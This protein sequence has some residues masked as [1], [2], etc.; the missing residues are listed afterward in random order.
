EVGFSTKWLAQMLVWLDPNDKPLFRTVTKEVGR[1]LKTRS[2]QEQDEFHAAWLSSLE[3][4]NP[5]L[6]KRPAEAIPAEFK[7]P[8]SAILRELT[9]DD[10][11]ETDDDEPAP[12][13]KL[14][15]ARL[16]RRKDWKD[17]DLWKA[18]RVSQSAN[19]LPLFEAFP[20]VFERMPHEQRY[21]I[22]STQRV[23]F[24]KLKQWAAEKR[25]GLTPEHLHQLFI[26]RAV[27]AEEILTRDDIDVLEEMAQKKQFTHA[28]AKKILMAQIDDPVSFIDSAPVLT[29]ML[30][31]E[32]LIDCLDRIDHPNLYL[33][34]LSPLVQI[35]ER[36]GV[37]ESEILHRY[38]RLF[39][40]RY[41]YRKDPHGFFNQL[42]W[43]EG[44]YPYTHAAGYYPIE[45]MQGS[46]LRPPPK[47]MP[48]NQALKAFLKRFED[49]PEE[50][51]P[52][53]APGTADLVFDRTNNAHLA[54][55]ISWV[56]SDEYG[57]LPKVLPKDSVELIEKRL[58]LEPG[59]LR[60]STLLNKTRSVEDLYS[61]LLQIDWMAGPRALAGVSIDP[62][63]YE[64]ANLI[65]LQ[66]MLIGLHTLGSLE[67]PTPAGWRQL[68]Q[69]LQFPQRL[70]AL[71]L[72]RLHAA[73]GD[74]I[75]QALE[76]SFGEGNAGIQSKD[77]FALQEKWGS[78][79][80]VTRLVARFLKAGQNTDELKELGRVFR[81]VLTNH[82]ED[83]KYRGVPGEENQA[84][85]Q[86]AH[87]SSDAAREN[88][89]KDYSV[90]EFHTATDPK[91]S[92]G[93]TG[94]EE[95]YRNAVHVQL[96]QHLKGLPAVPPETA[97]ALVSQIG[98]KKRALD[99]KALREATGSKHPFDAD[100]IIT[101]AVYDALKGTTDLEAAAE[102]TARYLSLQRFKTDFPFKIGY[103]AL[104]NFQDIQRLGR[105]S[106][107]VSAGE[108]IAVTVTTADPHLMLSMG[109]LTTDTSCQD[110]DHGTMVE[111][112]LGGVKDANTKMVL[113][114]TV[115]RQDFKDPK[116][117]GL[118]KEAARAGLAVNSVVLPDK[119]FKFEWVENGVV[120]SVQSEPQAFLGRRHLMRTGATR[121]QK[122]GAGVSFE[123]AYNTASDR[124]DF[125]E[126][127]ANRILG[128]VA[129]ATQAQPA[130]DIFVIGSRN[131][132]G[133]YSDSA[134]GVRSGD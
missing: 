95:S 111:S 40:E 30:S 115:G 22:L 8:T 38:S 76:K 20:E 14:I 85:E 84:K 10:F 77:L 2:K 61:V 88:W 52:K 121:G 110:F 124:T 45:T 42:T 16:K 63:L 35:L 93:A 37:T 117:F 128:R 94:F 44:L 28:E 98:D 99:L 122:P 70:T 25:F 51:M 82:F 12:N 9:R 23:S 103:E 116:A 50:G 97:H 21:R 62:V 78:L 101:A 130:V 67:N 127:Q 131:S 69:S 43:V 132:S 72:N 11:Y 92:D 17:E 54:A 102:L 79:R 96:P 48:L 49:N 66:Q 125:L 91:K 74:R 31:K 106:K 53:A 3:F 33:S 29:G 18:A 126:S 4:T 87:F 83:Y 41:A 32:D 107:Q 1:W 71:E 65:K 120:R 57:P 59:A 27:L 119:A 90:V 105:E 24:E 75:S 86:L 34:N 123:A 58:G 134:G 113:G 13:L 15:L 60:H 19:D 56:L 100:R 104:A 108:F 109:G 80:V 68:R 129:E 36:H 39:V 81:A 112:L 26:D 6:A 64:K 47:D 114:T 46:T 5:A 7:I 55:K 73:V 89:K 133:A 118:L